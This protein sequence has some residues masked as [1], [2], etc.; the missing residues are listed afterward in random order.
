M[1][2][3]LIIKG[4]DFSAV[5]VPSFL[6]VN[7]V[8][9]VGI[10]DRNAFARQGQ[11]GRSTFLIYDSTTNNGLWGEDTINDFADKA[12]YRLCELP[13]LAKKIKV[14]YSGVVLSVCLFSETYKALYNPAWSG[15]DG[16]QEIN[17][18]NYPTA[19]YFSINLQTGS[20]AMANLQID[21]T[22]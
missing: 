8:I 7:Q 5:A 18:A 21:Y 13:P 14:T 3:S 4:A 9:V 6:A 17:I 20:P 11:S 10:V 16:V 15:A 12:H 2:K 1:G 22:Y 19:R